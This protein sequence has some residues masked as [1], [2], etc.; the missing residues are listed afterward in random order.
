MEVDFVCGSW[1]LS[2]CHLILFNT[3]IRRVHIFSR[4][5][6]GCAR[7]HVTT[8]CCILGTLHSITF[9]GRY[10]RL[11]F[12]LH[13]NK[14][15]HLCWITTYYI[16]FLWHYQTLHRISPSLPNITSHS[17]V[18]TKHYIAFYWHGQT[19]KDT[20]LNFTDTKKH[21]IV[22]HRHYIVSHRHSQTPLWSYI[23]RFN[24][25]FLWCGWPLL[26]ADPCRSITCHD[27][28]DTQNNTFLQVLTVSLPSRPAAD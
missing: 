24:S 19:S 2:F 11:H 21:Y 17:I 3:F 25:R 15:L 6:C 12:T 26:F 10:K 22:S 16:E 27:R 13:S 23:L 14:V 5:V 20:P 9:H 7:V 1:S 4:C 8:L 28:V 18:I